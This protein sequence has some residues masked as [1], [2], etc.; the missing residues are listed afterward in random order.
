MRC[1]LRSTSSAVM[2]KDVLVLHAGPI[3]FVISLI[4][5]FVLAFLLV[6]AG[7]RACNSF[8]VQFFKF[9]PRSASA[10]HPRALSP[11]LPPTSRAFDREFPNSV[12]ALA[13]C[14]FS[15]PTVFPLP[16]QCVPRDDLLRKI[17]RFASAAACSSEFVNAGAS[18]IMPSAIALCGGPWRGCCA[19]AI[20]R[21]VDLQRC[22]TLLAAPR[23][24]LKLAVG[25][26]GGFVR[27]MIAAQLRAAFVRYATG[28]SPLSVVIAAIFWE[29]ARGPIG[30]IRIHADVVS[31]GGGPPRQGV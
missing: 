9:L 18:S 27:G 16:P 24:R 23:S 15:E 22:R 10:S 20:R 11:H 2:V 30:L 29:L 13:A 7:S 6:I 25:T 21:R 31:G 3:Q 1:S 17:S 4:Q 28:L 5:R 14:R 8:R 26:L 19:S 12:A